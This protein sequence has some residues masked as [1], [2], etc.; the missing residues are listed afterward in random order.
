[1]VLK[2]STSNAISSVARTPILNVKSPSAI[3]RV[4]SANCCIGTVIPRAI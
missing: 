2:E 4:P 3:R 1:M